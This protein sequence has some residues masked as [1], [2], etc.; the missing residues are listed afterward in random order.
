MSRWLFLLCTTLFISSDVSASI[1][2][3][4]GSYLR[5]YHAGALQQSESALNNLV[6]KELPGRRYARSKDATWLL[7]DRATTRFANGHIK[8]AIADYELA[9][10]A[11]DYYNQSLAAEEISKVVLQD[12]VGAYRA[13]DFEQILARVYFACALLY[14]GEEGNAMAVLRDAEGF[15]QEKEELYRRTSF[16]RHYRIEGN[17]L[18]KYLLAA[19]SQ[20][21]GD[22]S[23]AA[24]LYNEALALAPELEMSQHRPGQATVLVLCHNGN[25]PYKISATSPA[26]VA[27]ALALEAFLSTHT[28]DPAWS[29]LTG[30]PVPE[31]IHWPLAFPLATYAQIGEL[32]KPLQP[33]Y[34]VDYAAH[35]ELCQ[36]KPAIVARGVARLL[37]RRSAVGYCQKQHP[38]LGLVADLGMWAANAN[39][40]ADTRSWTTLPAALDLARFDLTAGE[41]LLT[42]SVADENGQWQTRQLQLQLKPDDL[43]LIHVFNIHPGITRIL[44][45]HR[46]G[47]PL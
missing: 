10:E 43:C 39:T 8:G 11:L 47:A 36:K 23:N 3:E 7:L 19:L 25:A 13:D 22:S 26:S 28:V 2:S 6:E 4:R 18:V 31:L 46:Y 40:R 35:E 1:L 14:A 37:M 16:T 5:P 27:S 20:K 9:L 32:G 24:L 33:C 29:S 45:P 17:A 21:R 30:I 42:L 44:I 38:L 12:E 41:Q 34:N 15:Q